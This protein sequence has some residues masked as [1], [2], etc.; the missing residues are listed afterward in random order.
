[1]NMINSQLIHVKLSE[2]NLQRQLS[3]D[4]FQRSATAVSLA[5]DLARTPGL[6]REACTAFGIAVADLRAGVTKKVEKILNERE[7]TINISLDR[8]SSRLKQ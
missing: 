4:F 8:F 6:R 1:M 5:F 2:I 3:G 7:K